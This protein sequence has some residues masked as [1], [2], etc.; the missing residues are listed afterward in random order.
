L[1]SRADQHGM[2]IVLRLMLA[3]IGVLMAMGVLLFSHAA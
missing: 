1:P 2:V 3:F